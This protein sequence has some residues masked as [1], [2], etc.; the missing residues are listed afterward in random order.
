MG[1]PGYHSVKWLPSAQ[2]VI[3]GFRDGA[4]SPV[5]LLDEDPASPSA[6]ASLSEE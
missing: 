1:V 2:V 5:S 6:T 3:L 4:S